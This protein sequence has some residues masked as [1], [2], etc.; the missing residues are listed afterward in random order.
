MNSF[1]ICKL[2]SLPKLPLENLQYCIDCVQK[3]KSFTNFVCKKCFQ[4]T[5]EN[6]FSLDLCRKCYDSRSFR[7]ST[8]IF[9]MQEL[10]SYENKL[11][12]KFITKYDEIQEKLEKSQQ[13]LMTYKAELK[14]S[15]KN[16]VLNTIKTLKTSEEDTF[17]CLN[18]WNL[19]ITSQIHNICVDLPPFPHKIFKSLTENSELMIKEMIKPFLFPFLQLKDVL[20]SSYTQKFEP[21][22][23]IF[24]EP[25]LNLFIPKQSN[26]LKLYLVSNYKKQLNFEYKENIRWTKGSKWLEY[27]PNMVFYCGGEGIFGSCG[28]SWIINTKTFYVFQ[29]PDCHN[30]MNHSLE[31]IED[32]ILV[33]GGNTKSC[34]KFNLKNYLW[35]DLPNN[36]PEMKVVSSVEINKNV[37]LCGFVSSDLFKYSFDSNSFQVFDNVF[38]K[39]TEKLLLKFENHLFCFTCGNIF[40]SNLNCKKWAMVES[41]TLLTCYKTSCH[42]KIVGEFFYF[43]TENECLWRFC[44]KFFKLTCIP[45]STIPSL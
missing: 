2:C 6:D 9:N 1:R 5:F 20:S 43:F 36:F 40:K 8:N 44:P 37:V 15:F 12:K 41:N 38:A 33:F 4:T 19:L 45:L 31:C 3:L 21:L 34:Q 27:S 28:R 22:E 42:G 7:Y 25:E 18:S 35:T 24:N 23:S 26:L 10:D 11:W 39:N 32:N 17:F 30:R 16:S 14:Q 29:I 13:S